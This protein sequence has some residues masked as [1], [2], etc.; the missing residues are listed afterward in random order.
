MLALQAGGSAA[1]IY[2]G[3]VEGTEVTDW[4]TTTTTKPL[5]ADGDDFH[6]THG[7]VHW[8][9]AGVNQQS[10]G[11]ATPGWGLVAAGRRRG[12]GRGW[13]SPVGRQTGAWREHPPWALR[14]ANAEDRG[15]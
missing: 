9:R 12:R 5:D 3:D 4:R 15:N 7:A 6:G 13:V 8:Q 10:L 14:E 2:L 1:T 11:P